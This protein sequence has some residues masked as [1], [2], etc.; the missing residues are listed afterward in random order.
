MSKVINNIL[1]KKI[2]FL[3]KSVKN[4][5]LMV[6]FSVEKMLENYKNIYNKR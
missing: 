6:N 5:K 2:D 1:N 4:S 3:E